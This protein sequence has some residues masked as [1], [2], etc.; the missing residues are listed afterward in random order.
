MQCANCNQQQPV[1]EAAVSQSFPQVDCFMM[2]KI[3]DWVKL[4]TEQT[5]LVM[6]P[7]EYL[8]A[9]QAAVE[10]GDTL[11]IN[12]AAVPCECTSVALIERT[13]DMCACVQLKKKIPL[14]ITVKDE[15]TGTT[16]AEFTK[17]VQIFD[18]CSVCFPVGMPDDAIQV[19]I[20][21]IEAASLS[22]APF[23]GSIAFLLSTCQ[24]VIVKLDVMVKLNVIGLCASR[25]GTNCWGSVSCEF[26][27]PSYPVQ[28]TTACV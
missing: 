11:D 24:E 27:T 5:T 15:T 23:D 7:A 1:A 28:C 4:K 26:G 9:I 21:G 16:L 2:Q 19:K 17:P 3:Y 14:H 18:S 22:T 10:A 25:A 13:S 8:P 20:V 6:I 12:A